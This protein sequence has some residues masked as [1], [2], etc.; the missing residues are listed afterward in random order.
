MTA[1]QL[2]APVPWSAQAQAVDDPDDV[3]AP[4]GP[5][6]NYKQHWS[7]RAF[8]WIGWC[9]CGHPLTPRLDRLQQAD[10]WVGHKREAD[11]RDALMQSMAELEAERRTG[12]AAA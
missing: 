3:V 10:D 11:F 1:R 5:H 2:E 8:A 7:D 12:V 9:V 4:A 6:A